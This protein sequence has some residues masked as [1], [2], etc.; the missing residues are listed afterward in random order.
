MADVKDNLDNLYDVITGEKALK[1]K[2]LAAKKA[3]EQAIKNAKNKRRKVVVEDGAKLKKDEDNSDNNKKVVQ[4]I[5]LYEWEAPD[6][7]QIKYNT[8]GF[9]ILVAFCLAFI[10]LLA[11][12]EQYALM[13]AIIALLFLLYVSSNTKPVQVK[14]KIT[15]RGVDYFNKMYEWYMLNDFYFCKKDDIYF[16]LIGTKLRFPRLLTLIVPKEDKDAIF[17]LLQDK[18]LYRDIRKQSKIDKITYGEYIPLE[19]V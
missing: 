18:L 2:E 7:Y 11:L 5:K 4:N 17:M 16:L 1:K 3:K 9:K 6:I 8:K 15:A 13:A 19:K 14:H 10:L 12:V